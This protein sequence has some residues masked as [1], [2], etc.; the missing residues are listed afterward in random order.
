MEALEIFKPPKKITVSE[1]ADENRILSGKDSASPGPW[2]TAKTPYLRDIMDAFSNPKFQEITFV[3][4]TQIG[5]TVAEQNMIGY[6]I[7]QDPGPMIVVY[8]TDKLGIFTAE[9]RLKPMFNLSPALKNKFREDK[10]KQDELQFDEMYI[11]IAGA[12]S[13][14]NLSSRPVRYVFFDEA[15][16]YPKWSGDEANPISLAE[17]RTKTFWNKKKVKVSSPV[18]EDGVIWQ[19]YKKA[20]LQMEYQVPCPHCGT[21]QPLFFRPREK[22][23]SGG[24][25]WPE[26]YTTPSEVKY[27]AYYQCMHC[28][29][30]IYDRQKP[31]MLRLG[32]WVVKNK[33][34][35]HASSISF[36]LNSIYS[37]WVTFGEVAEMFL[38]SKDIPEQLMNFINS[39]LAEPWKNNASKLNSDLI[40]E[41]QL[42]YERGTMPEEAQILTLGIDVQVDHFWWGVRA[43]GA[44]LKSWLVDY[45]RAE[46]WTELDEILERNFADTNGEIRKINRCGIDAGYNTD[47]VYLWCARHG[48]LCIPTK[49]SSRSMNTY[50]NTSLIDKTQINGMKL[51]V[52]DTDK[53]KDFI[54]GRLTIEAGDKGSW[55]VYKGIDRRYCDQVCSEQKVDVRK[56]NG[57]IT[58]KWEK[59]SSHAQNHM[60]D[61]ETISALLAEVCGV[62]YL[63]EKEPVLY[64][65]KPKKQNKAN[66]WLGDTKNWLK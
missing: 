37:P 8:P 48:G 62:R 47:E 15:E 20:D 46:T 14:S 31:E 11:A 34:K 45:G 58:Q 60:L 52:Y 36:H 49:G 22:G 10:S 7:D 29:Q 38:K 55:N 9:N 16:K 35:G 3:A 42:N 51:Y 4:G 18:L 43:W 24:I 56:K 23:E 40:M 19:S 5:K 44:G 25:M 1:W 12:N 41:K 39:W 50:Y 21:Y 2:R 17:E 61:V 64:K 32:K 54:A 59:I 65:P 6:A 57:L 28:K 26:Q 33:N 27:T 63:M 13:P 66:S 53:M 30:P